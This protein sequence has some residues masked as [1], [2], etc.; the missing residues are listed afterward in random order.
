MEVK[1]PEIVSV[2]LYNAAIATNGKTVS[3]S[4]RTSL[5]EIEI[6]IE[7]GGISYMDS[8]K[9]KL[10]PDMVICAKPG[11][12]RYTKLPF[13]CYYVHF[14]LS[15]G[16]LFEKLSEL[17]NFLKVSNYQKYHDIFQK[18][19]KYSKTFV[20]TDDVIIQS[21]VLEL[22]HNLINDSKKN[23]IKKKTNVA[24]YVAIKNTI[25]YIKNNL[26]ED[27]NLANLSDLANL[28]P[29]HFHKLFKASTG[30]TLHEYIEEQRIKKAIDLIIETDYTN[31]KI[32]YECGFSS[33]SYFNYAF[34]RKMNASPRE[35]AK[36]IHEQ[37]T[38]SI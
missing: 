20:S 14:I 18:L 10:K 36:N 23:E 5:F 13:K 27:L 2:G 24:N 29:T 17:P 30:K 31:A 25:A 12:T 9:M 38:K 34:K 6:P 8:D 32:A 28:S 22:F 35:Y 11:Q 7:K 21:L 26:S 19:Y 3:N 33:Q 1:L 4:R 37:Y 16:E 15:E